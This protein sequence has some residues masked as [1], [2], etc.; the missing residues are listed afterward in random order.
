MKK[1]MGRRGDG[2]IRK[3][4]ELNKWQR[5]HLLPTVECFFLVILRS[6]ATEN[7]VIDE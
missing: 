5:R 4:G 3:S 6:E 1:V 7:L 2:E